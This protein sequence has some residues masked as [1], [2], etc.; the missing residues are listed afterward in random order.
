MSKWLTLV[1]SHEK[2]RRQ[3][4]F[5]CK[6]PLKKKTQTMLLL[7]ITFYLSI[8]GKKLLF[9]KCLRANTLQK[10]ENSLKHLQ[11]AMRALSLT[12]WSRMLPTSKLWN[13]RLCFDKECHESLDHNIFQ[14]NP[15][16]ICLNEKEH[17]A[18][19]FLT[20]FKAAAWHVWLSVFKIRMISNSISFRLKVRKILT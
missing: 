20:E 15:K 19:Y 8:K 9:L 3:C 5:S 14:G 6:L 1:V 13:S 18:P 2:N 7:K 4:K 10:Q 17:S 12:N 11:K 16:T